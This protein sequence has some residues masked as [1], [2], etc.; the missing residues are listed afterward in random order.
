MID[1]TCPELWNRSNSRIDPGG[2]GRP[3]ARESSVCH[4]QRP[5]H[6][7]PYFAINF[8]DHGKGRVSS[9]V[10]YGLPLALPKHAKM[11][12]FGMAQ[13]EASTGGRGHACGITPATPNLF[14]NVVTAARDL[15]SLPSRGGNLN[16]WS[17]QPLNVVSNARWI[18]HRWRIL[19]IKAE[20]MLL[21]RPC[22]PYHPSSR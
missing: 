18:K 15:N 10:V 8:K 22:G 9:G 21:K 2:M 19:L 5:N 13:M 12:R 4:D 7:Y 20:H 17:L 11:P 1:F 14:L 6:N 3:N 16:S